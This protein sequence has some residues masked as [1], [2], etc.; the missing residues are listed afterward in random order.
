MV[1]QR[2]TCR[3]VLQHNVQNAR[4]AVQLFFRG[5]H[6]AAGAGSEGVWGPEVAG[7][8]AQG[9][10][11]AVAA[12]HPAVPLTDALGVVHGAIVAPETGQS[13]D[14]AALRASEP[15][16]RRSWA[17]SRQGQGRGGLGAGMRR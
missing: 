17:L 6:N 2:G 12:P 4:T 13:S 5:D 7:G 15:Q 8:A 14:C 1:A 9:S 11:Y 16:G 10:Q 3:H